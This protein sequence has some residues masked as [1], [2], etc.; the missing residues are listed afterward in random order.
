MD[1]VRDKFGKRG[2]AQNK[3]PLLLENSILQSRQKCANAN[4]KPPARG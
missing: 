3:S 1:A 4:G 2:R